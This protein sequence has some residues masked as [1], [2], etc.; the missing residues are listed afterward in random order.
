MQV[1]VERWK[2]LWTRRHDDLLARLEQDLRCELPGAYADRVRLKL[3]LQGLGEATFLARGTLRGFGD[4]LAVRTGSPLDDVLT[5]LF[6]AL[7][8]EVRV[9]RRRLE[10]RTVLQSGSFIAIPRPVAV[11]E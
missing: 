6:A 10:R 4:I 9:E 7:I 1:D 2:L 3:E 8:A 5:E 11:N